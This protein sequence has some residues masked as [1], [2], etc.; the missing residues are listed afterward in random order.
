MTI[1]S[2]TRLA[3]RACFAASAT[4]LLATAA[5]YAAEPAAPA[6]E[7]SPVKEAEAAAIKACEKS[8]C[9][10]AVKKSAADGDVK[11]DLKKTWTK[12][13]IAKSVE[14][15]H[16]SWSFGDARCSVPL[17]VPG[18]LLVDALTKPA[19][20][21]ALPSQT[22]HCEVDSTKEGEK[23]AVV[24]VDLAPS[25]EFKDGKVVKA[26]INIGKIEAPAAVKGAIW[27]AAKA[28]DYFGLFE[29]QML[30]GLN[31]LLG[32]SC[33]KHYPAQ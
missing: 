31:K 19:Q 1:R 25:F 5:A 26:K 20:T 22:A 10:V 11:C 33:P 21:L 13:D 3:T 30:E 6:K 27:T 28:E 16:L 15:K 24:N 8:L 4:L 12:A 29:G 2:A 17:V 7:P 18:Q 23:A 32:E 9:T 14:K